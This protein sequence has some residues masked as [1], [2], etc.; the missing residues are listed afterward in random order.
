MLA[1]HFSTLIQTDPRMSTVYLPW[2]A[3]IMAIK[4]GGI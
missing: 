1:E 3:T 4:S 2:L